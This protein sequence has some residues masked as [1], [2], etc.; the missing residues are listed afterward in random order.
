M[1]FV[2]PIGDSSYIKTHRVGINS[3]IDKVND[4]AS[5]FN[6]RV[7]L[8][9]DIQDVI[10]IA[11][12][13]WDIP[14]DAAPSF[15]PSTPK[16][17]G[18]DSLDFS[19]E[20]SD[21]VAGAQSFSVK[22]PIK[23]YVYASPTNPST[24]YTTTLELLMNNAI[25]ANA[26]WKDKVH[27]GTTTHPM[28]NTIIICSTIDISLPSTSSTTLKLLFA[29]GPNSE[30]ASN[31]SMGFAKL[32]YTSSVNTLY[33]RNGGQAIESPFTTNLRPFPY[34][35]IFVRQSNRRPLKRLY[36]DDEF[37]T[38]TRSPE[39]IHQVNIDTDNPPHRL[40]HL[41]IALRYPN[42]IDPGNYISPT[43]STS[44][45]FT[46]LQLA[47]EVTGSVPSYINQTLSW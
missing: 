7:R 15:Y 2:Q 43:L 29:S 10:G 5:D 28:N 39:G 26:T 31:I 18:I 30:T 46:I 1:T 40:T 12:T 6:Y 27:I 44:I 37:Y 23:Y 22:W 25:Q 33:I 38:R 21:I 14:F 16:V 20:N 24:D 17:V 3:R 13:S 45:G 32:D 41:D 19:L 36:I 4:N 34:I 35:D 9:N 47:N 11:V 8:P 42:Q